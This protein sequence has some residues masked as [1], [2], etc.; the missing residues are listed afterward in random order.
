MESYEKQLGKSSSP[1][2]EIHGSKVGHITENRELG[3]RVKGRRTGRRS[4]DETGA[5]KLRKREGACRCET[6]SSKKGGTMVR[7][8]AIKQVQDLRRKIYVAA[9]SDKQKRFWG[10]Y[11]HV[12]KEEVLYVAY[13]QAKANNGAPGIDRKTFK[14]IETAGLEQFITDLQK[15]LEDGTYRPSKNRRQ[16]I[17]KAPGKVRILG[18]PNIKDRVVQ[19]ALKLIL[20]PIFEADFADN[21]YGYRPGKSQH[22]A[23]VRVAKAGMK[24]LT[25]VID[26][27]LTAYFD[28][29]RHH[30]L[31]QKVSRRINDPKIMKLLK[32]ILK[33]NGNK[34]VPQGGVIS[35]LLSNIYLN[36]IDQMFVKAV[37]ETEY[38]GYQQ[39]EYCRYA[40]DMIILV[41]GHPA[42]AWLV[43]KAGR[44]LKEE[45]GRL[46]VQLNLEKTKIVELEK[47]E[48]FGFL[49]FEYRLIQMEKRKMVLIK[50]KE[51]KVQSLITEVQNHLN[52]HRNQNVHQ[53]IKGLNPILQG[54]VNYYRIGH[55]S[56][57]FKYIRE[58]VERK[59]R[60]FVGKSQGRSGYGWN[61]WSNRVVYEDWGLYND[62]RIHYHE[63]K[64]KPA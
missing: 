57:E 37:Q 19:G 52:T 27:D 25:K 6:L 14:D 4:T 24:R 1:H 11:R 36:G 15:E 45:L 23:V 39:I 13:R 38:K 33:A 55:S 2:G 29:I 12:I 9:K 17:P 50:P 62:Y 54:W 41:N 10:M 40:D 21:S 53:M 3:R 34:G 64:V 8:G 18:I 35:P 58:W 32:M 5:V 7:T 61:E 56:R 63:T 26:V 48:T 30:I 60:R 22:D 47:G 20:E 31:L 43:K 51:K 16:E 28:N 59:V 44:R 42:L 49:G 46:Q